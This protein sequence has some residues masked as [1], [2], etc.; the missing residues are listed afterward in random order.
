MPRFMLKQGP[1]RINYGYDH[2]AG[3][4][5]E[6]RDERLGL[7]AFTQQCSV[8]Y[9]NICHESLE[10]ETGLYLSLC[11]EKYGLG[12]LVSHAVMEEF[13]TRYGVDGV[14]IRGLKR[15]IDFQGGRYGHVSTIT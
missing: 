13:W 4:F 15:G 11:T 1:I 3:Y 5:F 6:L 8:G 14:H 12:R 2:V 10:S 7:S 9:S